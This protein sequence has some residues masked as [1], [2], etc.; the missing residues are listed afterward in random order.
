MFSSA[1]TIITG[2][3]VLFFVCL[4]DAFAR[5]ILILTSYRQLKKFVQDALVDIF[6]RIETFL[7]RLEIYTSVHQMKRWWIQFRR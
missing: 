5:T 3:G 6:E 2:V 4:L 7:Q 1:K